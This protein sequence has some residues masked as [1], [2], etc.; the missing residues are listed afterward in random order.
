MSLSEMNEAGL[1][2]S[3]LRQNRLQFSSPNLLRFGIRQCKSMAYYEIEFVSK[4]DG[5]RHE[6]DRRVAAPYDR[7]QHTY[8][9]EWNP[10]KDSYV[11]Y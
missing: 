10:Q 1:T 6:L 5:K 7:L 8:R 11:V 3:E 9:L 4:L 2:E